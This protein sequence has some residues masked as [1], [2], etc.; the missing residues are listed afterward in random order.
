MLFTQQTVTGIVLETTLGNMIEMG[1]PSTVGVGILWYTFTRD[2][3]LIGFFG[4]TDE[5][6]GNPVRLGFIGFSVADCYPIYIE[7]EK[8][9]RPV[10]NHTAVITLA[11]VFGLIALIVIL[12]I[13]VILSLGLSS[14]FISCCCCLCVKKNKV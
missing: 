7:Q 3:P 14:T 10:I 13:C 12:A 4:V 11:L 9:G 1:D 2:L 5:V 6:T 8:S